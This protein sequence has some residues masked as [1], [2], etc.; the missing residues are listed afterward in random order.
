M[1]AEYFLAYII[2]QAEAE[3]ILNSLYIPMLLSL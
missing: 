2:F 3:N 1:Y